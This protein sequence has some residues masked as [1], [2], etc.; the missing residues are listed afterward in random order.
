MSG[1]VKG[2]C[3][4]CKFLNTEDSISS[5]YDN[6]S[7]KEFAKRHKILVVVAECKKFK[8][9]E[10]IEEVEVI[11]GHEFEND[12]MKLTQKSNKK[13]EEKGGSNG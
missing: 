9:K 13:L 5:C 8:D 3:T 11:P 4:K 1:E 2:L 12:V 6:N 10:A 7:Y